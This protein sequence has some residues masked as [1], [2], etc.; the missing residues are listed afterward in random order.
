MK[1]ESKVGGGS[2]GREESQGVMERRNTDTKA[3]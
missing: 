2:G 1:R 3:Q